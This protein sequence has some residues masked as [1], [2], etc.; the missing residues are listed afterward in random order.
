M[1]N[2]ISTPTGKWV[3]R[4][5][6]VPAYAWSNPD[7]SIPDYSYLADQLR[8]PSA[9][10]TVKDRVFNTESEARIFCAEQGA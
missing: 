7:G 8:L 2:I 9:Y 3:L 1:V 10:R 4:G 5:W 6:G